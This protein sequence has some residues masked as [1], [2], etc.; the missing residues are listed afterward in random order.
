MK[1]TFPVFSLSSAL[2]EE[3]L[4]I[5]M[6]IRA[7]EPGKTLTPNCYLIFSLPSLSGGAASVKPVA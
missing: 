7:S 1:G 3:R 6:T 5:K 2:V 4:E